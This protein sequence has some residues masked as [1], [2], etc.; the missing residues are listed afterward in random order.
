MKLILSF[1][2]I[3][4]QVSRQGHIAVMLQFF[5]TVI[6]YDKFFVCEPQHI[7]EVLVSFLCVF[8]FIPD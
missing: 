5:E 7:P 4:S 3:T 1:Q 2:L 6:R 8:F